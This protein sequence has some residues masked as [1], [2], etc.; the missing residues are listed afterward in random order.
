MKK[1]TFKKRAFYK[2][3]DKTNKNGDKVNGSNCPECG[4][5]DLEYGKS[6]NEDGMFYERWICLEC[7]A[8]GENMFNL[9]FIGV[10][11]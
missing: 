4:S 3:G 2:K 11:V 6:Y 1:T 10:S 5:T 7:P 8:C 9:Q